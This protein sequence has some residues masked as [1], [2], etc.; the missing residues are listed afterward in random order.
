LHLRHADHVAM[1]RR[2]RRRHRPPSRAALRIVRDGR[3]VPAADR[4]LLRP[5]SVLAPKRLLPH[6]WLVCPAA[7]H[8]GILQTLCNRDRAVQP[9]PYSLPG[10]AAVR[11]V[12]DP[13]RGPGMYD[14][15]A[16]KS[17]PY[18]FLGQT[19]SLCE[20]CLGLVPAKIVEQEG[21]VY[22][23]K[24][25]PE[26]GLMKTLVSDDPVYWRR[27]LE[28]LKP[29]DRPLQPHTRTERGCPWDC[30]L[31]PDHEQHS[32][33]AIVEINEAC[34]LACPVCFA[35]SSPRRDSHKSLAEV[36]FMLD[37][38]VKSEG[39]P[40]LVQISGGEPTIHPQILEIL[41]AARRRPIKHVMLN[42]NGIRIAEDPAFCDA[43]AELKPGFEVYLQFDSLSDDALKNIRGAALTRIRRQALANLE[44]RNIST[45]L[46]CTVK[47]GVN[48]HEIGPI[49]P[50]PLPSR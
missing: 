14:G 27:T 25:C 9:L 28:Y 16:R 48:D 11:S 10:I 19:T 18:L 35:D 13:Q 26:H 29:G 42:T 40:D 8:V 3:H 34:N 22:Y 24:R 23:L 38:L 45:T 21:G 4:T 12:D 6:G 50:H 7:L 49:V 1:G 47:G 2:F 39:E 46:V 36:E 31:C 33:L 37:A 32:C 30:G 41:D 15:V 5:R 44:A 43:L 17:A 20:T